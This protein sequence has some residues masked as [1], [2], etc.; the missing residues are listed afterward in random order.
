[1]GGGCQSLSADFNTQQPK[2]NIIYTELH[3]TTFFA[4]NQV[5]YICDKYLLWI[6]CFTY[7]LKWIESHC[8]E[9]IIG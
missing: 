6:C 9:N 5:F 2:V 4:V 8:K 3:F 7:I 1:M